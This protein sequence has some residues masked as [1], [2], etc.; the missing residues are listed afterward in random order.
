MSP[1]AKLA[2]MKPEQLTAL[3][4]RLGYTRTELGRVLGFPYPYKAIAVREKGECGIT[5]RLAKQIKSL[6]AKVD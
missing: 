3:R 5:E 4:E 1:K 2:K 6:P